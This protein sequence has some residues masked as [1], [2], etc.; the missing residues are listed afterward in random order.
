VGERI[1]ISRGHRDKGDDIEEFNNRGNPS[2]AIFDISRC[3]CSYVSD[4][5]RET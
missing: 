4:E 2:K 3:A 5:K 1:I